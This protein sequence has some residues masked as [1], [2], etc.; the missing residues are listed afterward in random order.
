MSFWVRGEVKL[1]REEAGTARSLE[2]SSRARGLARC[3][4]DPD[5]RGAQ[6]SGGCARSQV[7]S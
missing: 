2:P 4:R 6:P 5:S 3:E 7:E 1:Q